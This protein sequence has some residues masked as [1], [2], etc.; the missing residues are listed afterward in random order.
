M[1]VLRR[2]GSRTRFMMSIRRVRILKMRVSKSRLKWRMFSSFL[3]SQ[4]RIVFW[5]VLL[6]LYWLLH[7]GI[8]TAYRWKFLLSTIKIILKLAVAEQLVCQTDN[9]ESCWFKSCSLNYDWAYPCRWK[10]M[11]LLTARLGS[12]HWTRNWQSGIDIESNAINMRGE[13]ELTDFRWPQQN[14]S[15]N[16]YYQL[17]YVKSKLKAFVYRWRQQRQWHCWRYDIYVLAK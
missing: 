14:L 8:L 13:Q 4:N 11:L 10:V 2:S 5:N 3:A 7:T 17:V 16:S 15:S 1:S 6:I 12:A 9:S